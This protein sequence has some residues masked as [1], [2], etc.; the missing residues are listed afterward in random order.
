MVDSDAEVVVSV[1][2]VLSVLTVAVALR[3]VLVMADV[4]L[5]ETSPGGSGVAFKPQPSAASETPSW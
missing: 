4:E 2:V 3:D 1:L 5:D